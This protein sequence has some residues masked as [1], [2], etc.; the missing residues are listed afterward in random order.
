M[1]QLGSLRPQEVESWDI[2][3][4]DGSWMIGSEDVFDDA[5]WPQR[6]PLG[7]LVFSKV[8]KPFQY[9]QA[10]S[11]GPK[12]PPLNQM[13]SRSHGKK[14]PSH[15]SLV[16]LSRVSSHDLP[17][18]RAVFLSLY[19]PAGTSTKFRTRSPS[20]V[21]LTWFRPRKRSSG[22]VDSCLDEHMGEAQCRRHLLWMA[23]RGP[24]R[25]GSL[26]VRS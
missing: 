25:K 15:G 16:P 21:D 22:V 3:P 18:C 4:H 7:I 8:H 12:Y 17:D 11:L 9:R 1:I 26:R 23:M 20:Q 14:T 5:T 10:L 24:L 6:I 19:V 13:L 2:K